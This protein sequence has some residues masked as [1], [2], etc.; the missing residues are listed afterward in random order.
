M[1]TYNMCIHTCVYIHVYVQIY[2]EEQSIVRQLRGDV[3]SYYVLFNVY[4]YIYNG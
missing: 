4:R 2:K 1:Y 3:P